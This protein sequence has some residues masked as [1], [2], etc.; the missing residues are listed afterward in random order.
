MSES[1]PKEKEESI[2]GDIQRTQR[3]RDFVAWLKEKHPEI[4]ERAL[5]NNINED[6]SVQ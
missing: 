5:L 2:Q 6:D 4:Y 1:L 3:G